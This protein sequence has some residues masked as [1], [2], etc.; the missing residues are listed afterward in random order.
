MLEL[1]TLRARPDLRPQ[2]FAGATRKRLWPEFMQRDPTATLVLR[3][4]ASRRVSRHRIR[5]HRSRC[6]RRGG[7]PRL[8]GAVCIRD[9]AG[10]DGSAGRRLGRRDPLGASLPDTGADRQ[11]HSA[12]RRSRCCRNAR[13]R[14]LAHHPRCDARATLGRL[15]YR[16]VRP[17]PADGEHLEPFTPIGDYVRRRTADGLPTDPWLL[18][19]HARAGGNIVKLA[20]AS[21]VIPGQHRRMEPLGIDAIY[22]FRPDR[23]SRRARARPRIAGTGPRSLCRAER[24]GSALDRLSVQAHSKE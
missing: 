8:R 19:V 4:R 1:V 23:G 22:G 11:R 6:T 7:R 9:L 14:R 18:R 2:L 17:R 10:S 16:H 15:G 21:M 12:L 20:P 24:L 5:H 3:R 13:A